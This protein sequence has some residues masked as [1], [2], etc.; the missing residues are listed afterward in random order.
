MFSAVHLDTKDT[1]VHSLDDQGALIIL[2]NISQPAVP[3][4]YRGFCLLLAETVIVESIFASY[5]ASQNCQT[6]LGKKTKRLV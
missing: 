4:Q 2:L 6:K 3:K 1:V 5:K